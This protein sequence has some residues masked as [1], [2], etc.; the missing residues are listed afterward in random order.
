[1]AT[2]SYTL[3]S[4]QT[5]SSGKAQTSQIP[6]GYSFDASGKLTNA[7]GQEYTTPTTPSGGS[8]TPAVLPTGTN[9]LTGTVTP[10]TN[11]D[12]TPQKTAAQIQS[13]TDAMADAPVA[14]SDSSTRTS[15]GIESDF[16]T[17]L[18]GLGKPPVAP[19]TNGEQ[20]TLNATSG[21]VND[22]QN[23]LDQANSDL[24]AFQDN[25]TN[26]EAQEAS[27]PGVVA[28]LINGRMKMISAQDASTLASL[29]ANVT[30]QTTNLKNANTAVQTIMKNNATDYTTA[31]KAYDDEYT[32]AYQAFT[33]SETNMTKEEASASANAKTIISSF[34]G[35]AAGINSITPDQEAQ[36]N[37]IETQA[38]LPSGFIKAAV[39]A[40][41]NITKWVKGSDGNTYIEGVDAN[42]VPYTAKV[43]Y[44]GGT[45]A[46]NKNTPDSNGLSPADQKTVSAFNKALGVSTQMT[47]KANPITREQF[48]RQL[49]AQYPTIN[50]DQI[51]QAVYKAYPDDSV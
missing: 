10:A 34:K 24:S 15:A 11:A 9:T 21:G 36:W 44:A 31:V 48:A 51:L 3:P 26:S 46:S 28:S 25:I 33:S 35:S 14:S 38:G 20:T 27:K 17:F 12:G 50:P 16:Q 6:T 29:K 13:E 19:D 22:T 5:I 45:V 2:P 8:N 37:N 42:G 41:L 7:S 40:E 4:G 49:Q 18:T 1:M 32:K 47:R 39:T 30:A 43:G 23:A